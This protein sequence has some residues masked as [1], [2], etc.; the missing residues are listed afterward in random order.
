MSIMEVLHGLYGLGKLQVRTKNQSIIQG[1][2]S[3]SLLERLT[4][5]SLAKDRAAEPVYHLWLSRWIHPI[6]I[7]ARL[8]TGNLHQLRCVP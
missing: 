8:H 5:R 3:R 6:L 2:N 7:K 4:V 1:S